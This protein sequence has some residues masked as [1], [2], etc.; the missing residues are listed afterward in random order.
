MKQTD[1][2][3]EFLQEQE[4]IRPQDLRV[5]DISPASLY[6]LQQQGRVVR[7]GRGLYRRAAGDFTEHHSLAMACKR[8]PPGVIC[9]LSAL[10]FFEIGTQLP[11]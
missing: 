2:I 8:T 1:R 10:S 4:V 9:P 5:L 11:L 6:W 7:D 3:I